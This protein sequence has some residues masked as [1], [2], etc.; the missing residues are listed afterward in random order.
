M[1]KIFLCLVLLGSVLIFFQCKKSKSEPEKQTSITYPVTGLNGQNL[2]KMQDGTQIDQSLE[3]SLAANLQSDAT[4][5]IVF[6]NLSIN[7]TAFWYYDS[8]SLKNWIITAYNS[9]LKQQTFISATGSSLDLNVAF[10]PGPGKCRIDFFE[11]GSQAVTKSVV[12][13]WN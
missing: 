3:F 12:L 2:L 5:K 10:L 8:A 4:L 6:N 13:T 7:P 9:T 11:N 1:K